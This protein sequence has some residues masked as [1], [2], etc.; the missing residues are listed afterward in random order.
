MFFYLVPLARSN[1]NVRRPAFAAG[2]W[3]LKDFGSQVDLGVLG[4]ERRIVSG[5]V[6]DLARDRDLPGYLRAHGVESKWIATATN[7]REAI[8]RTVG[9]ALA[10]QARTDEPDRW[11]SRFIHF[12][13]YSLPPFDGRGFAAR[14]LEKV[15]E[16]RRERMRQAPWPVVRHHGAPHW[17]FE[18]RLIPVIAGGALPA[19]DN[20]T[21]IDGAQLSARTGWAA[22]KGD[23]DI[24]TNTFKC[25][26]ATTNATIFA[27]WTSDAFGNDQYATLSVYTNPVARYCYLGA[28]VRCAAGTT[29]TGYQFW[30]GEDENDVVKLDAGTETQVGR[31]VAAP[32]EGTFTIRL[33]VSSTTLTP[34]IN[35][36]TTGTPGAQTDASI[37]SGS[38]GV[39][40]W[41]WS[42][43]DSTE[44]TRGDDWEAGNLGAPA[45]RTTYNTDAFPLGIHAGISRRMN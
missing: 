33:E 18:G 6:F 44:Y 3:S 34:T 23:F 40:G 5:D 4:V 28:A 30:F 42:S 22:N 13:H 25:D 37:A 39:S 10:M 24:L 45:G 17:L 2:S 14:W 31:S 16:L 29:V 21:G 35:G 36:S 7:R 38:A 9:L 11:L 41:Q 20:F 15:E 1:N 43:A 32:G 19:T 8:Q 12:G 26:S 27:H